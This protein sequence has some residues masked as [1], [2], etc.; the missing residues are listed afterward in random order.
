MKRE[1]IVICKE[2]VFVVLTSCAR[3]CKLNAVT[4][5]TAKR[6]N[7]YVTL[8]ALGGE[9]CDFFGRDR[10]PTLYNDEIIS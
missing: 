8:A 5:D 7:D 4:T 2:N 3:F 9:T 10:E 6:V 1:L